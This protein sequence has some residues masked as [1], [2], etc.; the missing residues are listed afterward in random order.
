MTLQAG[1]GVSG[2]LKAALIATFLAAVSELVRSGLG[3]S[4]RFAASVCVA[5]RKPEV[6]IAWQAQHFC[7]GADCVAGATLWQWN[8]C[9]GNAIG[10]RTRAVSRADFVAGAALLQSQGKRKRERE[11]EIKNKTKKKS[12]RTEK[13]REKNR[14]RNTIR[15]RA[16]REKRERER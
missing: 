13:D 1:V 3:T 7:T 10:A 15:K 8:E 2:W 16:M 11:R 6:Q 12:R 14:K 4:W 5:L 9:F